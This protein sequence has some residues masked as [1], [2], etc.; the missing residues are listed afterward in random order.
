MA[1]GQMDFAGS[2]VCDGTEAGG[3]VLTVRP[4]DIVFPAIV[5][6]VLG[7]NGAVTRQRGG[8]VQRITVRLVRTFANPYER[9]LYP[10]VLAAAIGAQRD[11]LTVE[12]AGGVR[13]WSGCIVERISESGDYV[14]AAIVLEVTFVRSAL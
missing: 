6:E 9:S 7:R 3:T 1:M 13:V 14:A 4:G 12:I 2:T 8:G 5:D 11:T 10:E